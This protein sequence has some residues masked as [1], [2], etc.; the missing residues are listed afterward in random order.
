M[1]LLFLFEV[2]KYFT[3]LKKVQE[4]RAKVQGTRTEIRGQMSEIGEKHP[5]SLRATSPGIRRTRRA[6]RGHAK[7]RSHPCFSEIFPT[8]HQRGTKRVKA[9][10]QA[11]AR[12]ERSKFY[13]FH[14][15]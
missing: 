9:T 10:G 14:W 6:S 3:V 11:T 1:V 5:P 13:V 2:S 12:P 15:V 7:I 4:S 8:S